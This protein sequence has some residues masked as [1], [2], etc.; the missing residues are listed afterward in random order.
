MRNRQLGL[1]FI[2]AIFTGCFVGHGYMQDTLPK[3]ADRL[4]KAVLAADT[5]TIWS[6]VPEDERRFYDLSEEKFSR[7]WM[8]IVQPHLAKL[9]SY[10]FDVAGTNGLEV[11]AMDSKLAVNPRR[12]TLLVSGQKGKYYV[13][14]IVATAALHSCTTDSAKENVSTFQL[15]YLYSR[16]ANDTADRAKALGFHKFRRGPMFSGETLKEMSLHFKNIAD[17]DFVRVQLASL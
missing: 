3:A 10:E 14:Y 1:L 6:F 5:A 12:F 4:A 17:E 7:Y 16:W 2:A 13:P 15:F 8:E 9:D 11:V